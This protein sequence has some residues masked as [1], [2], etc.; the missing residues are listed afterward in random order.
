MAERKVGDIVWVECKITKIVTDDEGTTY[1]VSPESE[2]AWESMK[3]WDNDLVSQE[4]FNNGGKPDC[5]MKGV[6]LD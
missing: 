1:R 2:R 6:C 4:V 3:V 5:C